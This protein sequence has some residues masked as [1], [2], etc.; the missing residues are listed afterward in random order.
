M[1]RVHNSLIVMGLST[2]ILLKNLLHLPTV[3]S[4]RQDIVLHSSSGSSRARTFNAQSDSG[5]VFRFFSASQQSMRSI[6]PAEVQTSMLF[7]CGLCSANIVLIIQNLLIIQSVI[8]HK[9]QKHFNQFTLSL[10]FCVILFYKIFSLV[11]ALIRVRKHSW[12]NIIQGKQ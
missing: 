11:F 4:F 7:L 9:N 5:V 8:C 3:A 2:A 12:D 1:M 10:L 6:Q